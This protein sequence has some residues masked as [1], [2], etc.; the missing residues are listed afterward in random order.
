MKLKY[1]YCI[2]GAGPSGLT[3]AYKLLKEGKSVV[4]IERENRIGGLA[5]S[6]DY[7]G[8]IFDIG[9]KRF[10]TDDQI[11]LDFIHEILRDDVCEI[12]RSTKVHFLGR[13]FDWPLNSKD[14]I[15]MPLG[16]SMKCFVELL[17]KRE[18]KDKTSFHEY[19]YQKY[20]ETLYDIFFRPY[21]H[22]FL[23]WDPEDVHSDWASTGINRTVIDKRVKSNSLFDLVKGLML[24][25]KIDTK[26]LYPAQGGFGGFYE[27][28]VALCQQ[29]DG[30]DV[31][32]SDQ[33]AGLTDTGQHL[34]AVTRNGANLSFGEMIW[35]GNLNDLC[36]LASSDHTLPYL[37]TIFYNIICR[38]EGV[39]S[40]KAQW[41][42][43]SDGDSLISR[44]T[45][46][47][48]FALYTCQDGYYN[49]IC[50]LTDSQVSPV[51]FSDPSKYRDGILDELVQMS[52][53]K[54]RKYV[55]D[56][57]VN[58]V[59]DTYP[60]YHKRYN[61]SFGQAVGAL[62]KF[63]QRIHLLGRCG[64]YWYNNSDHSMRFAIEMANKLLKKNTE[65]F[66]YRAYFGGTYARAA[67]PKGD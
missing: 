6:Y 57:K 35:T 63:S 53:L 16:V 8:Q 55:E 24:P 51:Y 67:N 9:P 2:V 44:I 41:I 34:D 47:K 48:E 10:H 59:R 25:S 3:A 58:P 66:D 56:I 27:K 30:F 36:S 50:E 61:Q 46:M 11:V 31:I 19:I 42:Y 17:Q 12:E 7:D 65:E 22:K 1:D 62:R 37:N 29:Q 14:L 43:V 64:A 13:Y 20:G 33:I 40:K 60:I 15:Q 23:R 49:F 21:T 26:F 45:C 18:I 54:D 38:Q 39:G 5:K 28:L 52:F 4:L 32:V